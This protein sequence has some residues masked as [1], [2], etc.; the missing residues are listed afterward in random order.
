MG[1]IN[2]GWEHQRRHTVDEESARLVDF[3][4]VLDNGTCDFHRATGTFLKFNGNLSLSLVALNV[5]SSLE[6]SAKHLFTSQ[7]V[8]HVISV[9]EK[10]E[11]TDTYASTHSG[12]LVEHK[13]YGG[14][15]CGLASTVWAHDEIQ[16]WAWTKN[17][18]FIYHEV[19]DLKPFDGTRGILPLLSHFLYFC[20]P[21]VNMYV[22]RTKDK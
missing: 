15:P 2:Q 19:V 22:N 1:Q 17:I 21:V 14:H 5:G 10:L 8:E 12:I 13:A 6:T 16:L 9:E 11:T 7:N 18:V 3:V 4:T 20:T